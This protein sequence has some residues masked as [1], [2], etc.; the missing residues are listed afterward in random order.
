[1]HIRNMISNIRKRTLLIYTLLFAVLAWIVFYP[2]LLQ[3]KTLISVG[4][5]YNQSL[6]VLFY[7]RQYYHS[8]LSGTYYKFDPAIGFGEDV[9]G[10]LFYYG[11]GDLFMFPVLFVSEENVIHAYSFIVIMKMYLAGLSFMIYGRSKGLTRTALI[12]SSL[13]YALCFYELQQ[14]LACIN[15]L[16]A[17]ILFPIMITAID[18]IYYG[19]LK[20]KWFL[21]L[22]LVV[23]IQALDGFY[24]LYIDILGCLVYGMLLII[25]NSN[26]VSV[27]IKRIAL[28]SGAFIIGM[29]LGTP[30]LYPSIRYYLQSNRT[31]ESGN[32]LLKLFTLPSI[33]DLGVRIKNFILPAYGLYEYGFGLPVICLVV[34]IYLIIKWKKVEYRKYLLVFALALYGYFFP[35]I[36]VIM[37]GFSYNTNRWFFIVFFGLIFITAKLLPEVFENVRVLKK[38]RAG[39]WEYILLANVVL[40]GFL[41]FA[42]TYIGGQGTAASFMRYDEVYN[43]IYGSELYKVSEELKEGKTDSEFY[44]VD[45]ND[46][47]INASSIMGTNSTYLYYSVCNGPILDIFMDLRVLP[48]IEAEFVIEGLDSRQVLESLFSTKVYTE[49]YID[50]RAK[51]NEYY[52]PQGLFFD[53]AVS[54]SDL[55]GLDYIQKNNALMGAL[56]VED[57]NTAL[58]SADL[59]L[60]DMLG[61]QKSVDFEVTDTNNVIMDGCTIIADKG[62]TITFSFD[63]VVLSE[64]YNELYFQIDNLRSDTDLWSDII[65]AGRTIRTRPLDKEWYFD[66]N[67][68]YLINISSVASK[69]EL[70]LEFKQGGTFTFDDMH[71]IL[72]ENDSFERLYEERLDHTL[73]GAIYSK[74]TIKGY[75]DENTDGYLMIN[76]PYNTCWKCYVDGV[77][78]TVVKADYSFMAVY[79]TKGHHEIEFSYEYF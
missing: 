36:G 79:L 18:R 30:I 49:D 66:G 34:F 28:V 4:D 48:S 59:M 27:L 10:S 12:C 65:L 35:A 37:N 69:G 32:I 77:E 13:S 56:V 8:L 11:I 55:N 33:A 58:G 61:Q 72:N 9:I 31:S 50:Q 51:E 45:L 71:M 7:I 25:F 63:P 47:S 44:R 41:F 17:P 42:P 26:T 1:M 52:L 20:R 15:M 43:G 24:F 16:V 3:S 60:D 74:D 70:I 46:S 6:P 62:G 21:I 68:D 64:S 19:I 73:Q 67:Y 75:T 2:V 14:G 22:C 57:D 76:L 29:V 40:V 54:E 23:W 38:V 53:C 39:I 78:V 5:N